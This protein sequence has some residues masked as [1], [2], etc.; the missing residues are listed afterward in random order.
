MAKRKMT[1]G[2]TTINKTLHRTLYAYSLLLK[3][4]L[5]KTQLC[6]FC[7]EIKETILHIFWECNIFKSLWL[8]MAEILKKTSVM[9]KFLFQHNI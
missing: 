9:Y 4:K 1:N 5:K 8:E 6:N 7:N 3:C 2:Q